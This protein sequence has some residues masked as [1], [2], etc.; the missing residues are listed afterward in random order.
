MGENDPKALTEK[1]AARV[2]FQTIMFKL[3]TALLESRPE[4]ESSV[5]P[6]MPP[7]GSISSV[8]RGPT[9]RATQ[10]RT[11][12]TARP[13]EHPFAL[14]GCVPVSPANSRMFVSVHVSE[15]RN[16]C[17]RFLLFQLHPC[18]IAHL[19]T[20]KA[21]TPDPRTLPLRGPL[22]RPVHLRPPVPP[23]DGAG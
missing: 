13:P 14:P 7:L 23:E 1:Y 22:R 11:L 4:G 15:T 9:V 19:G 2:D 20:S 8:R 5:Q 17:N 10:Q 21:R 16:L 6:K 18:S 3:S 12:A